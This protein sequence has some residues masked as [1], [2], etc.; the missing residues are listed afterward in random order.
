[1]KRCLLILV[2]PGLLA[3][4]IDSYR[5]AADGIRSPQ[6]LRNAQ[7][8][9]IIRRDHLVQLVPDLR[10]I[11]TTSASTKG[12]ADVQ[13]A[14]LDAMIELGETMTPAEIQPF[15]ESYPTLALI[16]A[17]RAQG[18]TT[19]LLLDLLPRAQ[20]YEA[21]VATANLL[22][23][24]NSPEFARRVMANLRTLLVVA[25]MDCADCGGG[26]GG[27][28]GGSSYGEPRQEKPGWP[29]VG[30]YV[31]SE[32]DQDHLLAPGIDS[33]YYH[34]VESSEYRDS[35]FLGSGET[36]GRNRNMR[37]LEYAATMAG[38]DPKAFPIKDQE[39]VTV[40]WRDDESF[41]NAV[42]SLKAGKQQEFVAVVQAMVARHALLSGDAAN[43]KLNVSVHAVDM[44]RNRDSPLPPV[45]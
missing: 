9:E 38:V 4:T 34:R 28:Y 10:R 27:G 24:R 41:V 15:A 20:R 12:E 2:A 7:A 16:L 29:L 8:I 30:H 5:E 3:Q 23:S 36:S 21:Y 44:R 42:R 39:S 22:L 33:I 13:L 18:D 6:P 1:M 26:I 32:S 43:L 14:A 19:A 35:G 40:Q 31:L 11:V 17:A 25:V 37:N 45:D